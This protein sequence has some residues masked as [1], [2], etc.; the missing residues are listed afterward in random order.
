LLVV[1]FE[2]LE[3]D[4]GVWVAECLGDSVG[5]GGNA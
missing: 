5:G 1:V 2:L 3:L 4:G